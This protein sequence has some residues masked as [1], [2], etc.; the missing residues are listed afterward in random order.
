MLM[1]MLMQTPVVAQP[2]L[3]AV[4]EPTAVERVQP[5]VPVSCPRPVADAG[6]SHRA[7]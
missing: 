4:S 2:A 6:W 5:T 1:L 3:A 7:A